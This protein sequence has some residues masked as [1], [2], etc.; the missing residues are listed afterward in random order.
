MLA[1]SIVGLPCLK[2]VTCLIAEETVMVHHTL[3]LSKRHFLNIS[4]IE[5]DGSMQCHKIVI[6]LKGKQLTQRPSI[7]HGVPKQCL[8]QSSATPRST[9]IV[10]TKTRSAKQKQ[11]ENISY[12]IKDFQRR[13]A[14]G[15]NSTLFIRR[16]Q[17][18]IFR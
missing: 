15:T 7:F 13:L 18:C 5:E 12:E 8:R 3:L 10:I 1:C 14:G 11:N 9:K 6:L 2:G 4:K 16:K 17:I